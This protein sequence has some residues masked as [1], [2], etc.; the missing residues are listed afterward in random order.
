MTVISM[1]CTM[2]GAAALSKGILK[3]I[4]YIGRWI[5]VDNYFPVLYNIFH[6]K[7][8]HLPVNG[9]AVYN[10][11]DQDGKGESLWIFL[12]NAMSRRWRAN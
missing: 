2:C 7:L 1:I 12:R 6:R 10:M 8:Q 3:A 5:P 9:D 4:E 11:R